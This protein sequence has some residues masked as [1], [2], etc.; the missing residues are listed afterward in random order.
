[1]GMTR[2]KEELLIVHARRRLL[3]GHALSGSPSPFLSEIP[4]ALV[5]RESVPDKG[6]N[7]G[8]RQMGLF[9]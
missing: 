6:R 9:G 5:R 4:E 1:V 7:K 2:A 3:Y 8:G